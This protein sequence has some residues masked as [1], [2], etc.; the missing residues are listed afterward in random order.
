M[1]H[2]QLE[3]KPAQSNS[4]NGS[5]DKV[6]LVPIAGIQVASAPEKVRTVLGSCI[7]I[8]I[9]DHVAK[10]GGLA[11]VILPSSKEGSGNPG[12]FV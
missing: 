6:Y 2:T 10:I 12:E 3:K 11:H 8:A 7:G 4:S 9:Y 1:P 5:K